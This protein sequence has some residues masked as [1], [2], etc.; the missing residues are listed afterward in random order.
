[1]IIVFSYRIHMRPPVDLSRFPNYF[2]AL[3]HKRGPCK[4]TG[5][6]L[7]K[8]RPVMQVH[9]KALKIR[10]YKRYMIF[11]ICY[12]IHTFTPGEITAGLIPGR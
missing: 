8:L 1:M 3:L 5:R 4:N 6:L 9:N 11:E 12:I 7:D 10:F 2:G